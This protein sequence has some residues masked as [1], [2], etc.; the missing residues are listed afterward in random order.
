MRS[1]VD[2]FT[3]STWEVNVH[4]SDL[5]VGSTDEE[6]KEFAQES[7]LAQGSKAGM[8]TLLLEQLGDA[9][10]ITSQW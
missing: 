1:N 7:K 9:L 4:V 10:S 3:F 6:V 8:Q 2:V 5:Y